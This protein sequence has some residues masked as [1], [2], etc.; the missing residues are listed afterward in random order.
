M[1]FSAIRLCRNEQID[2]EYRRLIG[3]RAAFGDARPVQQLEVVVAM[4]HTEALDVQ[5]KIYITQTD[6]ILGDQL[7]SF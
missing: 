3:F 2:R 1:V 7:P 6:T 4:A 5:C